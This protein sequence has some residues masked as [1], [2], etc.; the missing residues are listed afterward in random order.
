MND[1]IK[2]ETRILEVNEGEYLS[3]VFNR[4][5]FEFDAI[6]TNCI[7]N[8][9]IPGL[10]ATYSEI[11]AK[12]NS[13]IIEPNIPVI[14]GKV[15]SHKNL[16]G[17]YEGCK[18]ARI[19]NYLSNDK[20]QH[21][22]I[23]CTPEGYLKVKR[24]AEN[25]EV[26]LYQNYFMLFDECEKITQDID[27]RE[28]ISL[29]IND[30]FL[31][32]NKAFVSATPLNLRN[33]EFNNNG[34]FT[35]KVKPLYEHRKAI[36]LVTTNNYA[37]S[38]IDLFDKLKESECVCVFMNS[39]NGINKLINHLG[40]KGIIEYKVFCSKKSEIK[41]KEKLILNSFENLD[42]PL[43]KYNFFT[44]RFFSAVD[45]YSEKQPDIIILTD[46]TE[47]KHSRID[48]FT[49]TIQIYGRFRN[50]FEDGKKFKSLTHIANYGDSEAVLTNFEIESYISKSKMIYEQL[51]SQLDEVTNKGEGQA[52]ADSLKNLSYCKFLDEDQSLNYFKIDNFYDDE[53][54]KGYYTNPNN[55]FEAYKETK[56]F[57]PL[58]HIEMLYIVGDT[59]LLEYK[60]RKSAIERRIFLVKQLDA[61]YNSE[62]HYSIEEIE[63]AKNQFLN[64]N[65]REIQEESKYTISA[66]EKI[67]SE[68][69]KS[70]GY[71]KAE[72]DRLL[73]G[74]VK[75]SNNNRMFSKAVRDAIQKRFHEHTEY[76]K[77]ILFNGFNEIF[78]NYGIKA[79][80]N[81]AS[82]QKYFGADELKGKKAGIIKLRLFSPDFEFE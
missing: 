12:R 47:A 10:G 82:V 66:F 16:L 42:L 56:H 71:Y 43:V 19:K 17:V 51:K 13:I 23:L 53:R 57:E 77:D 28:Q 75:S 70:V 11:E 49:N 26:N 32:Q 5:G 74:H 9:T 37:S 33:P 48:P 4:A 24:I 29:P 64:N 41:F 50:T 46:L 81:I 20:I 21:K 54:V 34:F 52:L 7:F 15:E 6:P 35:L 76:N 68:A 8:K 73:I 62:N 65:N 14:D 3:S 60:K 18:D 59:A 44:S 63:F 78:R 40:E 72:I 79:K 25:E 45:I 38:I 30:F 27:Y 67:G 39:T 55:I 61:I 58:N 69:I 1:F 31:Y 80:V 22:K 2:L 36:D